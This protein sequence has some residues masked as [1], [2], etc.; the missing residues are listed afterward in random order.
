MV[1]PQQHAAQQAERHA[2]DPMAD[3]PAPVR[4]RAVER[5]DLLRV[6]DPV[7]EYRLDR[8]AVGSSE[9][10]C[11]GGVRPAT[12]DHGQERDARYPKDQRVPDVADDSTDD[13]DE[14]EAAMEVMHA[15][16]DAPDT[17]RW[18]PER[19]V[20]PGPRRRVLGD[21]GHDHLPRGHDEAG[22]N[23]GEGT[24]AHDGP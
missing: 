11:R 20:E 14:T 16:D 4:C 5:L 9:Q 12:E 22:G 17:L 19:L 24:H 10:D 2:Q 15:E 7:D 6:D 23:A 8:D 13:R 1:A 21:R 3:P 18:R